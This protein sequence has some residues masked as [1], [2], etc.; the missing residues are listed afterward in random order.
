MIKVLKRAAR[1]FGYDIKALPRA[2]HMADPYSPVPLKSGRRIVD[3]DS[4]AKMSL[5]IPGMIDP[6]SGK[7]LY[8][9]CY[10]QREE[11]DVVEIGSWQGRSTS[12]LARA[13][14]ESG[15]GKFYAIDH[16]KGNVGKEHFYKVSRDDLSD[17]KTVFLS[18]M[19][20]VGLSGDINLLDMDNSS[21]AEKLAGT[22]I[23]F[24][25]IDGDHTK[26]GVE[27]DISL[28]FPM[29]TERAIVAFDD[30]SA[31]FPELVDAVDALLEHRK[32]SRVTSYENTLIVAT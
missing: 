4:L 9:L 2:D 19:E 18:N 20:S 15:N 1:S 22:R 32:F 8:A 5:S 23:R 6:S 16:F 10:M 17:L 31:N 14:K 28:F 25:F 30:F 3:A 11:G 24:L 13:A 26:R 21:A 7:M 27:K 29:L 12:F